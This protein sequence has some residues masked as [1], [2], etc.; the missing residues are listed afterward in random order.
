MGHLTRLVQS[1]FRTPAGVRRLSAK[2]ALFAAGI[3]RARVSLF[4]I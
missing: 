3:P 1:L 2:T 4:T